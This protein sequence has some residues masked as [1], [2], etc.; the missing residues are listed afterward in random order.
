MKEKMKRLFTAI[1]LPHDW[2]FSLEKTTGF[3]RNQGVRARF[4]PTNRIHLT[5]N[6]IGETER[7]DEIIEALMKLAPPKEALIAAGPGGLFK[8]R[9]GD[10]IVRLL[11][12]SPEFLDYQRR[13]KEVLL[14]LGF[15]MD[16]RPYRPHLTL[17]RE[18]SGAFLH[19][20]AFGQAFGDLA[21]FTPEASLLYWSHFE[22]G[23]LHYKPLQAFPFHDHA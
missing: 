15:A 2:L 17:A 6:F 20:E 8:R 7:E 4:V 10:L 16:R 23:R 18:A 13:E 11:S 9:G 22:D 14:S 21:P 19:S 1:D 12:P 3:I 5:L